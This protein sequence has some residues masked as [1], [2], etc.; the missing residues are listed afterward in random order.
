VQVRS[1]EP[2]LVWHLMALLSPSVV[3]GI[4]RVSFSPIGCRAGGPGVDKA[5]R[6]V[7]CV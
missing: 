3:R 6:I 2:F 4:R 5:F 7:L 1:R